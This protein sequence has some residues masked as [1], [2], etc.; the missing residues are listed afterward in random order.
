MEMGRFGVYELQNPE[1]IDTKFGV[2]DYVG[3]ITS[4]VK[5]QKLGRP[6]EWVKYHSSEVFSFFVTLN[7]LDSYGINQFQV[8]VF[9]EG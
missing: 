2:G 4:F 8:I 6:T 3:D 7:L 5:I 9:L 1:P